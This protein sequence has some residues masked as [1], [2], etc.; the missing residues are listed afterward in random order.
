[1]VSIHVEMLEQWWQSCQRC[2]RRRLARQRT[3]AFRNTCPFSPVLHIFKAAAPA[4]LR[5]R[6]PTLIETRNGL[7]WTYP[8]PAVDGGAQGS[9]SGK[10]K[11][12]DRMIAG[13]FY[14]IEG[15][16]F[17]PT[18]VELRLRDQEIDGL[19]GEVL[20]GILAVDGS[21]KDDPE[22]LNFV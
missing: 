21:L 17:H 12:F 8:D 22:T 6:V 4:A 11:N 5:E 15:R 14:N 10:G 20:Y 9:P 3:R 7:Q 18:D 13:A 16:R 1:M 2:C 19:S